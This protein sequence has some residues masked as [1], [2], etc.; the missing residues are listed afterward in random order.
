MKEV[1]GLEDTRRDGAAERRARG[2]FST[3]GEQLGA[4]VKAGTPGQFANPKLMETRAASGLNETVGS[5]GGFLVQQDFATDL[6]KEGM[7]ASKVA[8]RCRPF[9]VS[10]NSNGVKIPLAKKTNR[11]TGNRWGGV[12]M[13]WGDEAGEITGTK[14][15]FEMLEL[16]LKKLSGLCYL[17]DEVIEDSNVLE[18]FV[19][20]AFTSEY[21]FEMDDAVIRGTG[22]GRP[23]GILNSNA[24]VTVSKEASQSAGTIKT[25]NLTKMFARL[26]ASS[27]DTAVWFFN[28]DCLPQLMQ[29]TLGSGSAEIPLYLPGG[30]LAGKPYGTMLG[31]PVIA[32]EQCETCG[33]KGDIILADC[34]KY[35]LGSKGGLKVAS[36]IHVRFV[37]DESVLRFVYRVDGQPMLP[38]PIT[39]YKGSN[40]LSPFVVLETR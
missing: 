36:S 8:S 37:Y 16:S 13:S 34:S 21:A 4:I 2:P 39:P 28:Q 5:Q 22:A 29:L 18:Q 6:L 25:A 32:L 24:L 1:P 10:R 20:T 17:T 33:T 14:P 9:P 15:E 11:T 31:L 23:L 40:T 12:R 27:I 7:E 19:R 35:L 38:R 26:P 3:F 30:N